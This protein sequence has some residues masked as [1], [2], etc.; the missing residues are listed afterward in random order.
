MRSSALLL[1]L[2]AG[3]AS[4]PAP[5]PPMAITET[6]A[7]TA[8]PVT[9]A[10]AP[11]PAQAPSAAPVAPPAADPADVARENALGWKLLEKTGR[12][13]DNALVSG[14]SVRQAMAPL[15][16][17]ARGATADEMAQALGLEKDPTPAMQ[18]ELAT[19]QAAVGKRE[20]GAPRGVELAVAN[21]VWID[22]GFALLP[23]YAK[24]LGTPESVDFAKPET[25]STINAWV[26]E[27]TQAKVPELLPA[28][29]VDARTRLVVTNA[30][31]FK[32][33]WAMPFSKALTK[34]EPFKT[35]AKTV[36]VPTMH[37]VDSFRYAAS[38]GLRILELRYAD[39][40]LAMDVVL[41]DDGKLP[42][43]DATKLDDAT[44]TLATARVNVSLPK[45]GFKSGG[46]LKDA[47]EAL[48]MKLAFTDR[49]DF[50]GMVGPKAAEHLDIGQVFHQ[51][52]IA[53]DETGTE[54]AAATGMVMRT[55]AMQLG[56]VVDFKVDR[57]FVFVLRETR[58][59]RILFT[60]RVTD[61]RTL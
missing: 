7:H 9:S 20:A 60:G 4:K 51:T 16:L 31:W 55:T 36:T 8:A 58:S 38:G 11:L 44:K 52:W 54:A 57:P 35:G 53:V 30:I 24:A 45:L 39:S 25:R 61:P 1:V 43:V 50:G 21:R 27:N 18:A 10:A 23:D 28:G 47:L 19:W 59:G 5:L 42:K 29:A 32:G 3:C 22:D 26:S 40:E 49:A 41:S 14:A 12:P 15:L 48:G 13:T 33:R 56:P 34:N 37:L 6:T 2:V 46:P 17:G